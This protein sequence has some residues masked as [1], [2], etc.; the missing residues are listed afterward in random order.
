MFFGKERE[1]C[2]VIIFLQLFFFILV[3]ECRRLK[4]EILYLMRFR[5]FI[6]EI[7]IKFRATS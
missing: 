4:I 6:D 7:L 2:F 1:S 5:D 3:I